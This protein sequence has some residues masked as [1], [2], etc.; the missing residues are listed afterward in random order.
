MAFDKL[1]GD[2]M[3]IVYVTDL[4]DSDDIRV[5]ESRSGAR[6]LLEAAQASLTRNTATDS[7]YEN[8][9]SR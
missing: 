6:F 9:A 7:Y 3:R 5:I 4:V 1:S 8:G 2:V